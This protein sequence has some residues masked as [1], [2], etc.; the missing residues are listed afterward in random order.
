MNGHHWS[1]EPLVME[2]LTR[3]LAQH[4]WSVGDVLRVLNERG[5]KYERLEEVELA[6]GD[7]MN[8]MLDWSKA[9]AA[10]QEAEKRQSPKPEPGKLL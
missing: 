10:K 3:F 1:L 2:N 8:A 4:E 5:Q 7:V 9:E 6:L